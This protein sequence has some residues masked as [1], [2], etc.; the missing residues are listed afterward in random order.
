[1]KPVLFTIAILAALCEVMAQ[2]PI[3]WTQYYAGGDDIGGWPQLAPTSDGNFLL[4]SRVVN[5]EGVAVTYLDSTGVAVWTSQ[6]AFPA[7]EL[8][9]AVTETPNHDV[10]VAGCAEWPRQGKLLRLDNSG[11][12]LWRRTSDDYLSGVAVNTD[13]E[14]LLTVGGIEHWRP[15]ARL[16]VRKWSLNGNQLDSLIINENLYAMGIF[17][18][19]DVSGYLIGATGDS[20]A[21][22][23]SIAG[24]LSLNWRLDL[25]GNH[26]SWARGFT[27]TRQGNI[28]LPKYNRAIQLDT[29]GNVAWDIALETS[30]FM[31]AEATATDSIGNMYVILHSRIGLDERFVPQILRITT[32]GTINW[33]TQLNH[34]AA[35]DGAGI[36]IAP[37]GNVMVAFNAF[38]LPWD[39]FY[40]T[41]VVTFCNEA[42]DAA[43]PVNLASASAG[44]LNFSLVHEAGAIDRLIVTALPDSAWGEITGEAAANWQVLPNGDGND[45]D[46]IVFAT[47]VP[48]TEGDINSFAIHGL[49]GCGS[50]RWGS[51]CRTDSM[52]VFH[53]EANFDSVLIGDNRFMLHLQATNAVRDWV[54][55]TWDDNLAEVDTLLMASPEGS[56][57]WMEYHYDFS[58]PASIYVM[59]AAIDSFGCVKDFPLWRTYVLWSSASEFSGIVQDFS[60]ST[61]PNPFNSLAAI[62]IGVPTRSAV[63]LLIHD[64][65]G[66]HITTL[67]DGM[68][69]AGEHSFTFNASALPSGIYFARVQAGKFVKTQ[70]L[71]LLK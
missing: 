46:S 62:A 37:E 13:D 67:H 70:K 32:T 14:T 71:L 52:A 7:T 40:T 24:D 65:L 38:G 68:L 34:L 63:S 28:L 51:G 55:I 9:W 12:E 22:F 33:S 26:Y 45:G 10:I 53:A 61:Y 19:P 69:E 56:P 57:D 29:L 30:S 2:P 8:L 44:T 42:S 15:G 27:F 58:N 4:T 3:A 35:A 6:F 41:S 16:V 11:S 23:L 36:L 54:L 66:R 31:G 25:T 18:R 60:I 59:P 47:D 1:M 39:E 64:L 5:P 20:G 49:T 43:H 48:L 50:L 17:P 21:V